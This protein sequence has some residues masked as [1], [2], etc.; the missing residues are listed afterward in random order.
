MMKLKRIVLGT[1]GILIVV[2]T[3]AAGARVAFRPEMPS[4]W[5][6]L[7]AGMSRSELLAI[8]TGQHTDMR[9]LKGFDVF[10]IN[11]TM[12]G[13]PS[14]WQLVTYDRSGR[15]MH[16]NTRFI[17]RTCGLLSGEFQSVL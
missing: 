13:A 16:A 9:E 6:R 5:R 8:V 17:H 15:V 12:L 10:T 7:H 14:Y 4:S 3:V 11:T 1:L 2:I